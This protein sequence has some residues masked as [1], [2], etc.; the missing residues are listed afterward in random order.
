MSESG[1]V[2]RS[3]IDACLPTQAICDLHVE[4]SAEADLFAFRQRLVHILMRFERGRALSVKPPKKV[5]RLQLSKFE[6]KASQLNGITEEFRSYI[7]E[8]LAFQMEMDAFDDW[9][10]NNDFWSDKDPE[11]APTTKEIERFLERIH[12][13]SK[14]ILADLDAKFEA[15]I[16]GER[17]VDKGPFRTPLDQLIADIQ[18]TMHGLKR[19]Q[20]SSA[21]YYD[22]ATDS[23]R[24]HL[25]D[26]TKK[27]LDAY[28]KKAYFS[29][30]ALG[31]RIVRALK[32]DS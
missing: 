14:Q 17:E 28:D 6:K 2:T 26:F 13:A 30:L 10:E 19:T 21:C 12:R 3:K 11:T 29:D 18:G 15:S 5:Q 4:Y 22:A 27:L 8:S 1:S 20:N 16:G 25:Y 31:K 7:F 24:G 23:Y 9:L 32:K